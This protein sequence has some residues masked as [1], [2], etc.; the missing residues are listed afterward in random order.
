MATKLNVNGFSSL[1]LH[2]S[3][4]DLLA[5]SREKMISMV[6]EARLFQTAENGL[7]I[8][9]LLPLPMREKDKEHAREI[10]VLLGEVFG[11]KDQL[12][13]ALR[14]LIGSYFSNDD[15]GALSIYVN[16][17]RHVN[18]KNLEVLQDYLHETVRDYVSSCAAIVN[19][20]Y[21]AR[22]Y[23]VSLGQYG[24][25]FAMNPEVLAYAMQ[26][27]RNETVLEIAGANGENSAILAFSGAE[28][29]YYN[30]IGDQEVQNFEKIKSGL[31]IAIPSVGEKLESIHG[32]CFELLKKKPQLENRVGL[33]L[34]R[35]LIHFFNDMQQAEF[36]A[37]L[38]KILKPGAHAIFTANSIYFT[39]EYREICKEHSHATA[40]TTTMGFIDDRRV[41]MPI[42]RFFFG[43]VVSEGSKVSTD[44]VTRFLYSRKQGCKWEKKR[45]EF[46]KLDKALQ[47]KILQAFK[48]HKEKLKSLAEGDVR[49]VT[50]TARAYST[51]T[52]PALFAKYGFQVVMTY[53]SA[54]SGHLAHQENLFNENEQAG[55]SD[56]QLVGVIVRYSGE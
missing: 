1:S 9:G 6:V 42:T 48:P 14:R 53:A 21:E 8:R 32:D 13:F 4:A 5:V 38:K 7:Q 30:D 54:F 36:F 46:E 20:V 15:L 39:P 11:A 56:A 50:S 27:A 28:R 26:L 23:A 16:M 55:N 10:R 35:N 31:L 43:A 2:H 52:L 12:P 51:Q 40:F 24:S 49:I 37:L 34:C 47:P 33:L 41:V 29:V 44:F 17:P 3:P 25:T 18:L 45:E 22:Q 19:R